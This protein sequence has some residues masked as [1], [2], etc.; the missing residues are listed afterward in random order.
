MELL[1]GFLFSFALASNAK[2]RSVDPDLDGCFQ[3]GNKTL[4]AVVR[5]IE[6]AEPWL[7][8]YL[9]FWYYLSIS[10]DFETEIQIHRDGGMLRWIDR[11]STKRDRWLHGDHRMAGLG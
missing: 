10:P 9:A 3:R 1:V 8:L 4:F 6:A 7:E 5:I 2:H 11:D